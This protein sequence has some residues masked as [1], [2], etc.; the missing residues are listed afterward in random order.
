MS[1]LLS[2]EDLK[3]LVQRQTKNLAGRFMAMSENVLEGTAQ[4]AAE[5]SMIEIAELYFGLPVNQREDLLRM[6]LSLSK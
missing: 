1:T 2:E 4:W 3:T 6:M 5:Q